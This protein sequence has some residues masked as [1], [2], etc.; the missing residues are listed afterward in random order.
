MQSSRNPSNDVLTN[1]SLQTSLRVAYWDVPVKSV[2]KSNQH[3]WCNEQKGL[4]YQMEWHLNIPVSM[5][6]KERS[7]V[8]KEGV[9]ERAGY[10]ECY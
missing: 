1:L 8:Q 3:Y 9:L 4:H 2:L 7:R 5:S 10:I 6:I